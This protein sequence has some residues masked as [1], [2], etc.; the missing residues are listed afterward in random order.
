MGVGL[1]FAYAASLA[2]LEGF[3][4]QHI[5]SLYI[6]LPSDVRYRLKGWLYLAGFILAMG[7]VGH[8]ET[9]PV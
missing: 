9:V 4:M 8:L 7:L 6:R 5:R 1:F 3:I 2:G